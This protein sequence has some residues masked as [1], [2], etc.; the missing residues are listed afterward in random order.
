MNSQETAGPAAAVTRSSPEIYFCHST[1]GAI[2]P[3]APRPRGLFPGS[4]NPLHEGH[5][6]LRTV[7]EQRLQM[8][9]HFELS[10]AN[11][12]KPDLDPA[13]VARRLRQFVGV[14]PI[15][16]TRAARFI[17][18]AMLFPGCTFVLGYDTAIRLVDQRYYHSDEKTRDQALTRLLEL[19]CRVLVAGR[20][21]ADGRFQCWEQAGVAPRFQPLF[22]TL[23]EEE[24]RADISSTELRR[25]KSG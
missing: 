5:R 7:A 11:V 10:T 20:L 13:E 12:D 24:F 19:E 22:L 18:K 14:A 17:E 23:T 9:V 16:V 2:D 3:A 4:F 8:A 1:S 15:W 6:Q 21:G 25:G